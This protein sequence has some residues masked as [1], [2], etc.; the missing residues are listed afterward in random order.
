MP[1]RN[2]KKNK[3]NLR[4]RIDKTVKK[5]QTPLTL[6]TLTL[7]IIAIA[8]GATLQDQVTNVAN[9]IDSHLSAVV[10][11][12]LQNL[13]NNAHI[14]RNPSGGYSVGYNYNLADT[15]HMSECVGVTVRAANGT[16]LSSSSNCN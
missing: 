10:N 16:I 7:A 6:V 2:A 1:R 4:C 15:I 12:Y 3:S 11:A 13:N 5:Y 8:Q 14:F 9:T